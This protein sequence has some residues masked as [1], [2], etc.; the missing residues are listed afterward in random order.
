[1]ALPPIFDKL[2]LPVVGAVHE[3]VSASERI[4]RLKREYEGAK[5]R[6]CGG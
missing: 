3:I 5:R 4:A 1:M 2:R 6:L